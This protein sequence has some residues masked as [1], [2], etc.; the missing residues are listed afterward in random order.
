MLPA[1]LPAVESA[2]RT[3]S[4]V[5]IRCLLPVSCSHRSTSFCAIRRD[6]DGQLRAAPGS[7]S[8][9]LSRW[10][11]AH[12]LSLR[13]VGRAGSDRTWPGGDLARPGPVEDVGEIIEPAQQK[14]GRAC[15]G[16]SSAGLAPR[17]LVSGLARWPVGW[18]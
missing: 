9:L 8:L 11:D 1:D 5:C 6:R 16:S 2:V 18:T 3:T 17:R 13:W 15:R 4:D 7:R 14:R 12:W 10:L